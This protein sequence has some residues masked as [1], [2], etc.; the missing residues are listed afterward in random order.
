M[1][2]LSIEQKFQAN[3]ESVYALMEFDHTVLDVAITRISEL[4]ERLTKHHKIENPR[5]DA[6]RTLELLK[7]IRKNDS[8]RNRYQVIF[9]QGVVLLVSYFGSAAGEVF[10]SFL[11]KAL[12]RCASDRLLREEIRLSLGEIQSLNFDLSDEIGEIVAGKKDISFHDMQSIARAFKDYFGYEPPRSND[13]NNIVL[14]HA[15]RHAIV[16]AGSVADSRL[17]RQIAQAQPRTAKVGLKEREEIRFTPD[18]VK[19]VGDSMLR[20]VHDLLSGIEAALIQ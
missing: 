18:E 1:P 13:V 14:A 15:C 17:M 16:H 19:I 2:F 9:N 12:K 10:K 11:P 20:Y 8:L 3:V 5:L 6:G 7:N 4:Q